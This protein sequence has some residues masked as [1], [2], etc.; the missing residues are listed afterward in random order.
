[1]LQASNGLKRVEP[2]AGFDHKI[3][4]ESRD[5]T[6]GNGFVLLY[7]VLDLCRSTQQETVVAHVGAFF[8]LYIS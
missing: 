8:L 4:K 1:M 5:K 3:A 2:V 7:T 6:E